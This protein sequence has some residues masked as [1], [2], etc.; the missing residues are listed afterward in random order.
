METKPG[1]LTTEFWLT[2]MFGL[3]GTG[4]TV[5]GAAKGNDV[6]MAA[7]ATLI[8]LTGTAYSISRATVKKANAQA[9]TLDALK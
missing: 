5:W 2:L 8:G 1:F 7:G 6:M 4:L 3:A 9:T